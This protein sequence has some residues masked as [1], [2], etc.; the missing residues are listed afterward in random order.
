MNVFFKYT[1][2]NRRKIQDENQ[3]LI[4]MLSIIAP[5]MKKGDTTII[6]QHSINNTKYDVANIHKSIS[7]GYTAIYVF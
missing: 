1:N 5:D 7:N 6:L 4:S 2:K 3:I